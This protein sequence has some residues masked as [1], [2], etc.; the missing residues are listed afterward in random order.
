ML[1]KCLDLFADG[2]DFSWQTI[3]NNRNSYH[4]Q[5]LANQIISQMDELISLLTSSLNVHLNVGQDFSIDTSQVIMSLETKSVESF[6]TKFTKDMGNGQVQLPDNF[7]SFLDS[8]GKVSIRVSLLPTPFR[9][10]VSTVC[11]SP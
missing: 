10:S 1:S 5:Q 4:Q 3:Q 6:S 8:K 9:R 7:H 2:S 11:C